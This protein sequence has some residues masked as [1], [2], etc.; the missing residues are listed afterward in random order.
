MTENVTIEFVRSADEHV[1][2]MIDFGQ[3]LQSGSASTKTNLV[4]GLMAG[5]ALGITGIVLVR[6]IDL[7]SIAMNMTADKLLALLWILLMLVLFNVFMLAWYPWVVTRYRKTM[8]GRMAQD[9][10]VAISADS[11]GILTKGPT[12]SFQ[13][14]WS[15]VRSMTKRNGRLELEA[16]TLIVYVPQRAFAD[17]ASFDQMVATLEAFREKSRK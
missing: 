15:E 8:I 12:S 2:V 13:L 1:G 14:D 5:A 17:E 11:K 3:R 10:K 7:E 9:Q 6:L 4:R 16:E